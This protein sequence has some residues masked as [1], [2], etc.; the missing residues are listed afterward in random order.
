MGLYGGSNVVIANNTLSDGYEG[1]DLQ[2]AKSTYVYRNNITNNQE[3][4]LIFGQYCNNATVYGNNIVHNAIGIRM[5][6]FPL[7]M[8]IV[9]PGN[10]VYRNNLV[11][12]SKQ[13]QLYSYEIFGVENAT[14]IISWDNGKIGNFWSDYQSKYP[15]A[16][17]VNSSGI[18]DTPYLI[19]ENNKDRY[20]LFELQSFEPPKISVLSPIAQMYNKTSVPLL[21]N[22]DKAVS[23]AGYS[24]DGKPNITLTENTTLTGLSSGLHN[25]TVCANDTFGNIGASETTTFTIAETYPFVIVAA[26]SATIVLVVVA[27]GLLV[28]RK[29]H[30]RVAVLPS[31]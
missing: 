8:G 21:F 4:G 14:D 22:V 31:S 12:N 11:G 20:P 5:I 28:Y 16:T 30:K 13:V 19:D 2:F 15:N 1:L 10:T 6:T 9:E 26:V 25:V 7:G 18:G 29:K 3:V 17:E 23:W 24:L 27:A